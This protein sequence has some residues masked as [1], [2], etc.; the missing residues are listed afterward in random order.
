M[1]SAT[2]KVELSK[3]LGSVSAAEVIPPKAKGLLVIAHGAGAGMQHPFL[4]GLSAELGHLGM[5]SL[6]FNFHYMERKK[7]RP[8]P[9]AIACLAVKKAVEAARKRHP[10]LPLFAGGKSFGGRMSSTLLSEGPVAGVRGLVFFGFPLHP[11]GKPSTD[12][13]AH[14]KQVP[15]PMLFLQGTRDD[16]AVSK[17]LHQT[18]NELPLATLIEF[19]GADHSFKAGKQDL[20]PLIAQKTAD[21]MEAIGQ[22]AAAK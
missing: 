6:R 13:G 9:P 7:G 19:E 5:A 11:P 17:L 10:K 12:R 4:T 14:L 16:F 15:V 2:F 3:T 18:V 22:M 8:D 1:K 21:W 20:L